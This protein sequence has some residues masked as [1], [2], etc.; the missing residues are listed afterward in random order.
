M[1]KNLDKL[2][3]KPLISPSRIL[4]MFSHDGAKPD[5][6]QECVWLVCVCVCVPLGYNCVV[7]R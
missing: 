5:S 7:P 2:G 6:M 1:I 4:I 3:L